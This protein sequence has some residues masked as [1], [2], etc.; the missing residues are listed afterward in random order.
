MSL[1]H[2]LSLVRQLERDSRVPF[3]QLAVYIRDAIVNSAIVLSTYGV[4]AIV[5]FTD[6][7][8]FH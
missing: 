1:W 8:R 3:Q 6:R 5:S 4:V 7:Y 2:R